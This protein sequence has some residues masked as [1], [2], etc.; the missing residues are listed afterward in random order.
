MY[1]DP[2]TYLQTMTVMTK[3]IEGNEVVVM[4][5]PSATTGTWAG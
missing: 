3:K 5:R 4:L 2:K 1:L